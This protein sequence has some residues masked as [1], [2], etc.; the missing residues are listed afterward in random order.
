MMDDVRERSVDD[1]TFPVVEDHIV[2]AAGDDTAP[3]W[4][5]LV[6]YLSIP[7]ALGIAYFL[8]HT[9]I[10][11]GGTQ[12]HTVMEVLGIFLVLVVGIF[13][14]LII[15]KPASPV[16]KFPATDDVVPAMEDATDSAVVDGPN[17]ARRRSAVYWGLAAVLVMSYVLL[18]K[19]T[20][21]GGAQLHTIMEVIATLLALMVGAMAVVRFYSKKNNTFLFI[22]TGF[23]G[24]A[25][26]DGYHAVVTSKF[27]APYLPSDLPALIPWSWV[28]SRQFLSV[29]LCLS[30]LAW[31]REQRLGKP[32]RISERTVYLTSGILTLASFL[33][34]AFVP[35]PRAYYPEIIFHRPEEF[36]PAFFFLV[37]LIGYL[38]KGEWRSDVFEHWL[39]LSLIVGFLG[40]TVFMS[41]SG[42]LFDMEFDAAHLLKKVSYVCVLIGLL[43]SRYSSF[44][45]A[46]EGTMILARAYG[47]LRT[48]INEREHAEEALRESEKRLR[49]IVDNL[50]DGVITI[51][52]TGMVQSFNPGA[53]RIFGYAPDEVVGTN[54]RMLMPEPNHSRHDTYVTDY[55]TTGEAKMIGKGREV[56]GRRKNGSIFPLELG[57]G[58]MEVGGKHMFTGI[59]RDIT[60]RKRAEATLARRA[61]ELARSNADLEE[62][63]YVASHDLQEPLRK[64]QS[65][66]GRLQKKYGDALGEE[67]S[68]YVVRMRDAADRMQ[69]LI[70]DLLNFSRVTTQGQAFVPVDLGRVA[71]EVVSDLEVRIQET[72]GRVECTGLPTIDA[73]PLQIHQLLQNLVVN[74][75]KY[76]REDAPPVVQVSARIVEKDPPSAYAEPTKM[77][78]IVVTDNGIG[79]E[80]QYADRIFGIFQRLHGRG[81]YEGTGVGL[82]LCRKIAE[83]HGGTITAQGR[84]GEGA[85]FTVTL[86]VNHAKIGATTS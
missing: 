76:R 55:L 10:L 23:L 18:R 45:R 48:E 28:A 11:H 8:I 83:R 30:W 40:Q 67:G 71:R 64:V 22:G 57:I 58:E 68:D 33:F 65:F 54:V 62:F 78:E 61:E 3:A 39:V 36:L 70:T 80:E 63:A 6:I 51:D 73:D 52:D 56:D 82:A 43:I 50:V 75:L 77:C 24:T 66:G 13:A 79:F 81:K 27:F 49:A 38:R 59:V 53:E 72:D 32:G 19:S 37:A 60:E 14:A 17:P 12:P 2:P 21:Q 41:F 25:F 26:L 42:Q 9:A 29:L 4:R 74:A 16:G 7:A 34:F 31:V 84:P 15:G 69:R 5:R 47:M 46:E 86:P 20:W 85:T 1:D 35:L 44:R